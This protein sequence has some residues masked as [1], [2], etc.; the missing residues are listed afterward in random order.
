MVN[1]E[2][3]YKNHKEKLY[4]YVLSITKNTVIAEDIT[5]E[6]FEKLFVQEDNI[7]NPRDGFTASREILL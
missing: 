4:Y 6:A 3:I 2:K 7:K 1:Y 5:S